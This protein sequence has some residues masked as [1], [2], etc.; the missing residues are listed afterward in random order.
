M[1]LLFVIVVSAIKDLF[2]DIQRHKS[3]AVE[4]NRKVLVG[5][6]TTHMFELKTWKEVKIG[7]IVKVEKD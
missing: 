2:E 5:D 1:P 3:D 6:R 4:N 7:S